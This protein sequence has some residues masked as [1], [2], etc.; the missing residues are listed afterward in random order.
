LTAFNR[1]DRVTC[2]SNAAIVERRR[3]FIQENALAVSVTS[4]RACRR[5]S[6]R[7]ARTAFLSLEL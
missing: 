4:S 6:R 7:L 5:H 1:N 3:E 2:R